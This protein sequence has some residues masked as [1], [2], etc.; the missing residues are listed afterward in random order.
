[1]P[2][3]NHPLPDIKLSSSAEET[4]HHSYQ[5]VSFLRSAAIPAIVLSVLVL[6]LSFFLP[7]WVGLLLVIAYLAWSLSAHYRELKRFALW[8]SYPKSQ[9]VPSGHGVWTDIFAKLYA[10]R[11]MDEKHE[12][13][14]AEWLAR[15]QNTM[16]H[17]PDG[18]VLMDKITTLEWANPVAEQHF[19]LHLQQDLGT[20][21]INLVREPELV[22]AIKEAKYDQPFKIHYLNHSLEIHLI[23]FESERIILVS[24]DITETE[25][26]D[27]MRR[28]FIANA[29]HEL[30]TPL[31]VISGF[32][33]HA[34]DA[35]DMPLSERMKQLGLMRH[36]ADRMTILIQDMLMLSRLES[37][38]HVDA[39]RIDMPSLIHQQLESAQALSAGRHIFH[40][41]IENIYI[42]GSE[43]EIASVVG[44]LLSNAVRYTPEGGEITLSWACNTKGQPT[45]AVRDT[46]IGI[47]SEHLPRLTERFYRVNTAQSRATKGTGLGLAIVK[48]VLI[49]HHAQLKIESQ[50]APAIKHGTCFTVTFPKKL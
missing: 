50:Q 22:K 21:M 19:Q 20:R 42:D 32:L 1:M 8:L 24:R 30:R 18:V 7:V 39:H 43:Q 40:S 10:L 37:E 45:L 38:V 11:R 49:R 15:F 35:P 4:Y 46:G 16:R 14:L 27:S 26:V 3:K 2:H 36:Q 9:N 31:T 5:P 28:D 29:S 23:Q 47:A 41:T 17:L 44:N 25:R 13:Q 48:H 12:A 33:E 6:G 34:Q